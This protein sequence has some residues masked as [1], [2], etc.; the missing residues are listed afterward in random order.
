[1]LT[2]RTTS[3]KDR[4][5]TLKNRT[6]TCKKEFVH[7]HCQLRGFLRPTDKCKRHT[8]SRRAPYKGNFFILLSSGS[9]DI[10]TCFYQTEFTFH[11]YTESID[12]ELS[13]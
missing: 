2:S 6:P 5:P 1:M 3:R 8:T 13:S 12:H 11:L 9:A 7:T 4:R 10:Q